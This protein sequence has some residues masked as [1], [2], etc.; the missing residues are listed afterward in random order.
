LL[1]AV[2]AEDGASDEKERDVGADLGG[3]VEAFSLPPIEQRA[4]DG[5]GT[6]LFLK[7]DEGSYGV[8]GASAQAALDGEAFFDVDGD[9][10]IDLKGLEGEFDHL[11]GGVAAVGWDPGV[12]G[13]EADEYGWGGMSGDGDYVIE[14]EGL[15][16]GGEA[17]KPIRPRR[18]NIEAEIDLGVGTD[19]GGHTD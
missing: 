5:W 13:S 9:V 18:S 8:C 11:P 3:K 16:D 10:G 19:G 15:V 12:V 6:Q 14:F 2:G 1:A 7:S 4:L 17:V